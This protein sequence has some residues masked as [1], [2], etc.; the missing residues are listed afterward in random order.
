MA[1]RIPVII[2][3]D[4]GIDDALAIMLAQ[5]SGALDIVGIT[6]VDGNVKEEYTS[7]NA[8]NLAEFLGLGCPVTRGATQPLSSPAP[9]RAEKVHGETGF[10]SVVL[11]PAKSDFDPRP[12]WD[13]IYDKA[14]ELGHLTI[15]AIGPLTN[16]ATLLTL[17]GDV[18]E[19]IDRIIIM[20][21]STGP[22]NVTEFSE[23]NFWADPRAAKIVFESGIDL[24]MVGLNVTLFTGVPIK[25]LE[26]IG[27][28]E[29][30]IASVV[31]DMTRDYS[32]RVGNR[33]DEST[34]VI[35]DAIA[36]FYAIHPECCTVERAYVHI[37]DT[38]QGPHRGQSVAEYDDPARFNTTV[39]TDVDM[40]R[41]K[42]CYLDMIDFF[43]DVK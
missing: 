42:Q 23:F 13:F 33:Q 27:R 36:V 20:G 4:P 3:T 1:D 12:A 39:I 40:Q 7:R 35:H 30:R 5:A 32:D 10:G 14:V 19:H 11:S 25:M 16:I 28:Q 9:R 34:S 29:T 37:D 22:G 6:P 18:K 38:E 21:G 43:A 8:L 24:V 41:Y 17:H 2:D 26:E 31:R 15:I